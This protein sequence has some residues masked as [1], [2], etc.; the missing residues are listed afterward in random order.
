M[1]NLLAGRLAL[2]C[3]TCWTFP[4]QT[5][6][7]GP[8]S[9]IPKEMRNGRE[10]PGRKVGET[11]CLPEISSFLCVPSKPLSPVPPGPK[12]W[13]NCCI[14]L[15]L[16]FPSWPSEGRHSLSPSSCTWKKPIDHVK[17][18]R[19]AAVNDNEETHKGNAPSYPS[20]LSTPALL[21]PG[22]LS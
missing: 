3:P 5:L 10:A 19:S 2:N 22:V 6:R 1:P 16:H 18:P 12:G 9:G 11:S 7:V 21:R 20:P 15:Q 13:L 4:D 14:N 8:R 17:F